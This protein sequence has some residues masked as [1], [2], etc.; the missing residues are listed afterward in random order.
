MIFPAGLRKAFLTAH[1]IAS[2]G[3]IGAV[4]A[5]LG[6]SIVGLASADEQVVRG[7]YRVMEPVARI[8]L[9]PLAFAA[10]LTGI[11]QSLGTKWGLFQH[12]WVIFKLLITVFATFVL[13]MYMGT[14]RY[15]SGIAGDPAANLDIVRNFSPVLH[16][17]LALFILV[18]ATVLAIF[19]PQGL[20][21]YGQRKHRTERKAAVSA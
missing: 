19:K 9:I 17:V 4:L 14:F 3:W 1:V 10:L 7:V 13:L 20:T 2:V 18:V 8:V 12:Y 5:F 15:M 6:L 16:S 11:V 21:P